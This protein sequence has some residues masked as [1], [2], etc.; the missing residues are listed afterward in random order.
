MAAWRNLRNLT[1][2]SLQDNGLTGTL[3]PELAV[4]CHRFKSLFI[5][6]NKL[7]GALYCNNA[8]TESGH[9]LVLM[10]VEAMP[11]L[12]RFPSLCLCVPD[13]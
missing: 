10:Q 3:P 13:Q 7:V 2:L 9:M 4:A 5:A 1:S 8:V 6:G 11:L 12:L